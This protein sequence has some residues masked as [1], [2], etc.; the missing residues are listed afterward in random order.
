MTENDYAED[1]T[2]QGDRSSEAFYF[3]VLGKTEK[4]N[5]KEKHSSFY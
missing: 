5:Q 2:E 4:V 1:R 3:K